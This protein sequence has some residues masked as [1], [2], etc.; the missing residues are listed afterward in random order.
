MKR[1]WLS[2]RCF[3]TEEKMRTLTIIYGLFLLALPACSQGKKQSNQSGESNKKMNKGMELATLGGGCFWCVEGVFRE[4]K[5]VEKVVSGYSGGFKE[6]PSYREVCDGSTGHAEVAQLSYDPS[7]ISFEEILEVFFLVHDPTTLNRQGNDVG[8]QY[9]SVIFYHS[10]EQKAISESVI[11]ALNKSDAWPNPL[12]T[13]VS[14]FEKF[15]PAEDY[16]QNYYSLNS[17]QP[18]CQY[19]VRPKLEKF[20]KAFQPKLKPKAGK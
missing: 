16:H 10:P 18:Y 6:N 4:L 7:V 3:F 17:E 14:A 13:E 15:W 12:V 11:A 9:R 8:T 5:G 1:K 20:R 19:V 2:S